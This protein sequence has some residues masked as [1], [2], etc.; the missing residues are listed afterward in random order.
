MHVMSQ[1]S[2]RVY[3]LSAFLLFT[4]LAPLLLAWTSG[5]RWENLRSGFVSTGAIVVY[6]DP[7]AALYI[8]GQLRGNTPIRLSHASPGAY[9]LELRKEGYGAWSHAL[10]VTPNTAQVIGPVFLYPEFFSSTSIIHPLNS[11]VLV[12]ANQQNIFSMVKDADVTTI[13]PVFPSDTTVSYSLPFTPTTSFVSPDGQSVVFQTSDRTV[14]INRKSPVVFWDI[15]RVDSVTWDSSSSSILYGIQKGQTKRFDY[16]TRQIIDL[17]TATSVSIISDRL[18]S[19][20]TAGTLTT[21]T[22]KHTFGQLNPETVAVLDGAWK[23]VNDMPNISLIQNTSTREILE[24]TIDPLTNQAQS[25]SFGP[26]DRLWWPIRGQKPLW[27]NGTD[28]YTLND[29]GQPMIIDRLARLPSVVR[30]VDVGHI[31]AIGDDRSL[32]IRSISSRQGR[33]TLLERNIEQPGQVLTIDPDAKTAVVET[34]DRP[35][36]LAE[37]R[38]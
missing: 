6:S 35:R 5:Y 1:F 9:T 32:S 10:R 18:W 14:F 19:T 22:R 7:K 23:L 26:V 33:S 37:W 15:G 34:S 30:W 27:L 12:T 17:G 20:N 25:L 29:Q 16:V 4:V 21:V 2:R 8:N 13:K 28:L 38:W 36:Q 24:L 11:S 31:L 3:Y